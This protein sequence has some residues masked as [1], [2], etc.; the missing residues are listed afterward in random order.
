MTDE[1]PRRF[2][3]PTATFV[4]VASMVG[5]GIL[6]SPGYMILGLR[7]YPAV[8]GL[9]LV[10]GLLALC[11]ALC[12]AELAAAMPRA[13]GEYVYLREAY[14]LLPAFLSG[15]TSFILGFAAPLAVN[16]HLAASY[17]LA[18]LGIFPEEHG[19]VVQSAA[20]ILIVALTA[21][22]LLGHRQSA[23]TQ[24]L[25]TI[26]KLALF[27]GLVI[28]GFA[29]GSGRLA[30]LTASEPNQS[31]G[32]A[33]A[34]TQLFYV[35]FAYTGWNAA[36]YVA[37][38]VKNPGRTLPWSLLLGCGSVVVLYLALSL[39][40]AYSLP[41]GAIETESQAEQTARIAAVRL[42]GP[43]VSNA[44]SVAVGLTLLATISAF[45]ITGPRVYY[46]MA[47]DGVFPSLAARLNPHTQVPAAAMISQSVCAVVIL[48]SG[49]FQDILQFSAVGLALFSVL[50]IA[51][52]FVL[53]R[54]QPAMQRPFRTPGYPIVP[55][56]YL[57]V[58][59]WMACFAFLEWTV[60]SA[61]SVASILAGIPI[62]YVW[63]WLRRRPARGEGPHAR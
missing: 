42:F 59:L 34:A 33:A 19:R 51:A 24:S 55:G 31:I 63:S 58:T 49:T 62:Y 3:T 30:N 61:I 22:N 21:P 10:G 39:V 17:L 44:F 5:I 14:G 36:T 41:V 60:P 13:G 35:M 11:G 57:L 27:V 52:V 4:V 20:A 43:D 37:G 15:W 2:G 26:V 50:T 56:L 7:N 53:R 16:S 47:R 18:P 8:F 45:V 9:W 40:F 25:T 48:F 28:A 29:F 6:V 32:P 54:R 23:W 46:A 38:E 12:V 1:L